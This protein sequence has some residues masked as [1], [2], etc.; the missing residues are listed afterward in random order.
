M[1]KTTNILFV[2]QSSYSPREKNMKW[3]SQGWYMQNVYIHE[4]S[5][6]SV[7]WCPWYMIV[8]KCSSLSIRWEKS[9]MG[10]I[11][12]GLGWL[13][14]MPLY[15]AHGMCSADCS[16]S[17]YFWL[18]LLVIAGN[19]SRK[20]V[21][22]ILWSLVR[23]WFQCDA[24]G[25][26]DTW[27]LLP[28]EAAWGFLLQLSTPGSTWCQGKAYGPAMLPT[29]QRQKQKPGCYKP[30]PEIWL[31]PTSI[32]FEVKERRR[33]VFALVFLMKCNQCKERILCFQPDIPSV[34]LAR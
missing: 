34:C 3:I 27:Q 18:A 19:G 21:T 24:V 16:S 14:P 6:L 23:Y 9:V 20:G 11:K 32:N 4:R 15:R 25:C 22:H 2:H 13:F 10:K 29:Q 17:S 31:F 7:S 26:A 12:E 8:L 1:E 28:A 30:C 5:F 33:G